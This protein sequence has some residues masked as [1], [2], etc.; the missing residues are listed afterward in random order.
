METLN[1]VVG[2]YQSKPLEAGNSVLDYF[3]SYTIRRSSR[4]GLK[5]LMSQSFRGVEQTF[6]ATVPRSSEA[7][8]N[9]CFLLASVLVL[10]SR[11]CF[12]SA[13]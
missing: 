12:M 13:E 10:P 9:T 2:E 11:R 3:Q 8:L 4:T 5:S 1:Q 6:L 7:A